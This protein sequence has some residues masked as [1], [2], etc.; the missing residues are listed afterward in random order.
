MWI[1]FP[2]LAVS[3]TCI[4]W[5]GEKLE[6]WSD[7]F[8]LLWLVPFVS[9]LRNLCNPQDSVIFFC[10]SQKLD[11]FAILFRSRSHLKAVLCI[12]R[13]RSQSFVL[14]CF[15]PNKSIQ[16][17][18]LKRFPLPIELPSCLCWKSGDLLWVYFWICYSL[19]ICLSWHQSHTIDYY[20]FIVSFKNR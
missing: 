18:L 2:S 11:I 1:C 17:N 12:V 3:P 5:E 16:H 15:F 20:T 14:L 4:F 7:N 8:F 19:V 10:F 13:G 6:S 9:Y